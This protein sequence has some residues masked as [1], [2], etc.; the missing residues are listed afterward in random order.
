[1]KKIR[2]MMAVMV[3][4]LLLGAY[5]IQAKPITL[6][7]SDQNP[8]T[9]WGPVHSTQIWVK[10]IEQ[11]TQGKVKI[12][13][14]PNQT[15]AKGNKNWTAVRDGIAD[16]SW[17]SMTFYTGLAPLTEVVTL[18]G[19]PFKTAEAGSEILWKLYTTFPQ[20]RNELQDN[21][22]LVLYTNEPFMLQTRE[23]Q[24]KTLEDLKGLQ[25]RTVGGPIVDTLK[26]LG[27]SPI[28]I[29]MPDCY[30]AMQ[31]GTIDGMQSVWEAIPGFRLYEVGKYITTNVPFNS[32]AFSLVINKK[33]WASLPKDVKDAITNLSG[34]EGATFFGRNYF[35]SA[36]VEV[37]KLAEEK[38]YELNIYNL[39]EKERQRWI[40]A[41]V[42]PVWEDWVKKMEAKG[43]TDAR[44]VL[45]FVLKE[46]Q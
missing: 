31:K 2:L 4:T 7:L 45:D 13:I 6:S 30:V 23:K 43:H 11:A 3:S 5:G 36:R 14:Y 34:M 38:G 21:H 8:D 17:N 39:P 24:I 25:I 22:V 12:Q 1:M 26:T 37:P 41:G 42:K 28:A 44:K 29:P 18:P 33:K 20:V 46:A 35:D 40:D 16:M 32:N 15:L 27:A 19:L 10:K 9:S